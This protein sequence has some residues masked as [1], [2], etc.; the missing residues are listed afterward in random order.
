LTP[1]APRFSPSKPATGDKNCSDFP[2]QAEAQAALRADPSD[3]WGLDRD[4]NGIACEGNRAPN[5]LLP[6]PR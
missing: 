6:V 3:P 4:R 2:S 1:V 5:D